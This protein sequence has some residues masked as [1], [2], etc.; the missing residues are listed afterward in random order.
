MQYPSMQIGMQQ[1]PGQMQQQYPGQMQQQFPGHMQQQYPG[2]MQQQFAQVHQQGSPQMSRSP[3]L[4]PKP[5][6]KSPS[7][8]RIDDDLI[9][10]SDKD[11]NDL[12]KAKG[13]MQA[14]L[15]N[16]SALEDIFAKNLRSGAAKPKSKLLSTMK[17]S[18]SGLRL[19]KDTKSDI[20]R[21]SEVLVRGFAAFLLDWNSYGRK[22]GKRSFDR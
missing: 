4:P 13:A 20:E 21:L 9:S 8:V 1:Y 17:L 12:A 6:S 11:S 2:H 18:S 22:L 15:R 16:V 3:K 7:V 10:F 5:K 14:Y 19:D